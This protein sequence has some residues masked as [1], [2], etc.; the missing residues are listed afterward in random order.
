MAFSA[1]LAPGTGRML[2][3]RFGT[4]PV[5]IGIVIEPGGGRAYVA[6]SAADVIAIVDLDRWQVIDTL[7]AGKEP[8]GMAY[9]PVA[10]A[11]RS[12]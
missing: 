3:G 10:V 4:S 1:P 12:P 8:D 6:L 11:P 7:K 2:A 5:P 9:S